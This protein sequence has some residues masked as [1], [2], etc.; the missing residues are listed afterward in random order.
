M[1]VCRAMQRG[2][3]SSPQLAANHP[4]SNIDFGA[5]YVGENLPGDGI[6]S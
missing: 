4:L 6:V 3:A 5:F 1:F 2:V